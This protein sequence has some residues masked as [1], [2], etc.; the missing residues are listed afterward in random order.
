MFGKAQTHGW[1]HLEMRVQPFPLFASLA[2]V[3]TARLEAPKLRPR[4]RSWTVKGHGLRGSRIQ[5]ELTFLQNSSFI[6]LNK[7]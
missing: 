6:V 5:N 7:C 1:A 3:G 2:T 4:L